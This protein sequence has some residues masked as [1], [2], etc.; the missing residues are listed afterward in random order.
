LKNNRNSTIHSD[1][2]ILHTHLGQY[3]SIIFIQLKLVTYIHCSSLLLNLYRLDSDLAMVLLYLQYNNDHQQLSTTSTGKYYKYLYKG[4][5]S[6][7]SLQLLYA[8]LMK[9]NAI[10]YLSTYYNKYQVRQIRAQAP[11]LYCDLI[12]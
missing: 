5:L 1:R 11:N 8:I 10:N 12:H 3:I 9:L 2:H 6:S 7:S 4:T